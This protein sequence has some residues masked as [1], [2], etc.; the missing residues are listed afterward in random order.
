MAGCAVAFPGVPPDIAVLLP[1]R[2]LVFVLGPA[3]SPF[4]CRSCQADPIV[5]RLFTKP[6]PPSSSRSFDRRHC[7]KPILASM[8]GSPPKSSS[9]SRR[10]VRRRQSPPFVVG[11]RHRFLASCVVFLSFWSLL[12]CRSSL[13]QK[14]PKPSF[15]RSKASHALL[16]HIESHLRKPFLHF[17]VM[18]LLIEYCVF[19]F[20]NPRCTPLAKVKFIRIAAP[21]VM[22]K[23]SNDP[24]LVVSVCRVG[25]HGW[26]LWVG[27]RPYVPL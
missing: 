18:A 16:E 14:L 9:L 4:G 2:C 12:R 7:T 26:S 1:G 22:G 3:S 23:R 24:K 8:Q 5:V 10:P 21:L 17:H 13:S 15:S 25:T 20:D 27:L 19:T 11:H 6:K